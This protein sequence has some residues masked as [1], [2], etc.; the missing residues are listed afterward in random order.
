MHICLHLDDVN[1]P[2]KLTN[3]ADFVAQSFFGLEA[4]IR[5]FRGFDGLSSVSG[6]KVMAKK[7][8]LIREIFNNP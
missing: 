8:K 7:Q 5:G 3:R 1:I 6:S 4:I 2:W